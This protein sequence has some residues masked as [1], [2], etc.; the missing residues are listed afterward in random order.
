MFDSKRNFWIISL[1]LFCLLFSA[2]GQT[3]GAPSTTPTPTHTPTP[4]PLPPGEYEITFEFSMVVTHPPDTR[5]L[6]VAFNSIQ[7]LDY[8]EQITGEITFGTGDSDLVLGDGWWGDEL[9]DG[10]LPFQWAGSLTQQASIQ[11]NIPE[12]TEALLLRVRGTEDNVWMVVKVDGNIVSHQRVDGYWHLAYVPIGPP[13]DQI[14]ISGEIEWPENQYFPDFPDSDKVYAFPV[15]HV[16]HTHEISWIEDWRIDQSYDTMMALTLVGMQGLINREGAR[17]YLDWEDDWQRSS[18]WIPNIGNYI[19][20]E[21]YDFDPLSTMHFLL[22]RFGDRFQGAVRYD[23]EVPDTINIATTLAGLEDRIILAPEQEGFPGFPV[24]PSV[25][26]VCSEVG[27]QYCDPTSLEEN[28]IEFYRWV[29]QD[30]WPHLNHGIIGLISPGPPTSEQIPNSGN[31]LPLGLSSRDYIIAL[32]LPALWLSPPDVEDFP[33]NCSNY[34][35]EIIPGSEAELLSLYIS[36][37]NHPPLVYGNYGVN[38]AGTVAMAS[39]YGGSVPSLTNS[40]SPISA[41]NLTV[42][43]SLNIAPL[44]LDD[45]IDSGRLYD[46]LDA[47]HVFTM[48]SSDG[49]NIQYQLDRGFH[50]GADFVWNDVQ[51][52]RFGW[53]INPTLGEIAPL[54]WNYYITERDQVSFVGGLS[55]AGY[56]YPQLMDHDELSEYLQYTNR[57]LE[58]TGIK[59]LHISERYGIWDQVSLQYYSELQNRDFLGVFIGNS[60]WPWSPGFYYADVPVPAISP[61]YV[62]TSYNR[63]QIIDDFLSRQPGEVFIDLAGNQNWY[64][65]IQGADSYLWHRGEDV[66]LIDEDVCLSTDSPEE[67]LL[68]TED[69]A[70]ITRGIWGPFATLM[71]GEYAASYRMKVEDNSSN[72]DV[73]RIYI[74]ENQD[75]SL[76][77]IAQR[78]IPANLF[79]QSDSFQ[80]IEIDFSLDKPMNNIEFKIDFYG[81]CDLYVDTIHVVRKERL[82]LPAYAV[83]YM[84]LTWGNMG[85]NPVFADQMQEAGVLVLTPDEF[86]ASINPEFMTTWATDLMSPLH[87][88]VQAATNFLAEGKYYESLISARKALGPQPRRTFDT[89][90]SRK[91]RISVVTNTWISNF[92]FDSNRRQFSFQTHGYP[93]GNIQTQ[94]LIPEICASEIEFINEIEVLLDGES[95]PFLIEH[96]TAGLDKS[97]QWKITFQHSQG[98]HLIVI[99]EQ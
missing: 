68:F 85:D 41:S 98:A 4:T 77:Q 31:Y 55:G 67:A 59:T 13:P 52:H 84:P 56:T 35:I 66:C 48:F 89:E 42:F 86:M 61:S 15:S 57:Y 36:E 14:P 17:V 38:E 78:T 23:P 24:Y 32:K 37:A 80:N 72:I 7:F 49:D 33:G 12:N 22:R 43:T 45:A 25:K 65:D 34:N 63:E 82:D 21:Y 2:C 97:T 94:I 19:E 28:K 46:T 30:L 9:W 99:K 79:N 69:N 3:P 6:A 39:L 87:P 73:A 20:V 92:G 26:D 95:V 11:I 29:Y 10:T 47:S 58:D 54:V 53:T 27:D 50:G 5:E 96:E 16:T 90:L 91:C 40:N 8:D 88:E 44:F 70:P 60:G 81:G 93:E 62:I 74:T 76:Q 71:P 75:C 64:W 18:F 83:G 1:I 51:G